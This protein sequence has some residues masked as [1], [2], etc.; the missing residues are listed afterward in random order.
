MERINLSLPKTMLKK[1]DNYCNEHGFHRS[2]Y[3]R[4]LLRINLGE[5]V[6]DNAEK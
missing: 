3:I 6:E 5:E 2:E 4:S 1:L